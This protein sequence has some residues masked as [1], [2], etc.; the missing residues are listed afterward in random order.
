[1]KHIMRTLGVACLS[2][3]F[4]MQGACTISGDGISL[5]PNLNPVSLPIIGTLIDS[6]I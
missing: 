4:V 6:I 1:M 5:L 3:V 2:S